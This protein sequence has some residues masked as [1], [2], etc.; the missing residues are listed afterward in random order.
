M[1]KNTTDEILQSTET[2]IYLHGIRAK[3]VELRSCSNHESHTTRFSLL[4]I[5]LNT[6]K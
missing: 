6:H 4:F 3:V 5:K 2:I 1:E